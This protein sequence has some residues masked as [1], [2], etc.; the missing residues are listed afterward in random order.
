MAIQNAYSV[1]TNTLPKNFRNLE[2][3]SATIYIAVTDEH[4]PLF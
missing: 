3:K 2:D 4:H 1:I